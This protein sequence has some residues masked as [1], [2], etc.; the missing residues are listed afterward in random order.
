MDFDAVHA[1]AQKRQAV[2]QMLR[3]QGEHVV[4]TISDLMELGGLESLDLANP[5]SGMLNR[6][7]AVGEREVVTGGPGP[8]WPMFRLTG[9]KLV[10][11]VQFDNWK[12]HPWA[13]MFDQS[14][15]HA[16][17]TVLEVHKEENGW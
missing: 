15:I 8:P 17:H 5:E 1:C 10:V 13:A 6:R 14:S 3:V 12:H 9:I 16:T 4:F 7:P 2:S 11:L